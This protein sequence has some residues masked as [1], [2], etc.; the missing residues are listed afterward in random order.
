VRTISATGNRKGF[1]FFEVMV[2]VAILS[3]GLVFVYKSLLV[4]V[5]AYVSYT[6]RLTVSTWMDEKVWETQQRL[7]EAPERVKPGSA[8]KVMLRNR[9]V[10]WRMSVSPVRA[11]RLFRLDLTCLWKEGRRTVELSRETCVLCVVEEA[12]SR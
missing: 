7:L 12:A 2:T 8:G 10:S 11:P 5:G 6:N 4:C 3:V 9:K 1:T